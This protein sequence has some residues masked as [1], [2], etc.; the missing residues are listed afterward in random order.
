MGLKNVA[1]QAFPAWMIQGLSR[2]KNTIFGTDFQDI[3]ELK[4]QARA[5]APVRPDLRFEAFTSPDALSVMRAI[6][7][8]SAAARCAAEK[9]L[10]AGDEIIIGHVNDTPAFFAWVAHEVVEITYGVFRPMPGIVFCYNVFTHPAHR[11]KGLANGFYDW[12]ARRE[13]AR[14]HPRRILAGVATDNA[15]AIAMHEKVG[16]ARLGAFNT[17]RLFYLNLTRARMPVKDFG[18]FYLSVADRCFCIA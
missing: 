9:R 17:V 2:A 4:P 5:G 14:E 12:L 7:P 11:R 1:K 10:A 3:L 13:L 16:F 15:P 6:S 18:R 8:L